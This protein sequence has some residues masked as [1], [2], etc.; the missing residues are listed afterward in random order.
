M[1]GLKYIVRDK[2]FIIQFFIKQQTQ[3][4]LFSRLFSIYTALNGIILINYFNN[5]LFLLQTNV[6]TKSLDIEMLYMA[7]SSYHF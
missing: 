5:Y 3:I 4:I 7:N 2:L 6:Q 1:V